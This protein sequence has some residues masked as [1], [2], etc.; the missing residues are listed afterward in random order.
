M[1]STTSIRL[2]VRG[3]Q[4]QM[5][6]RS[7]AQPHTP[8]SSSSSKGSASV[9]ATLFTGAC[10]CAVCAGKCKDFIQ[11]SSCK[12]VEPGEGAMAECIEDLVAASESGEGA[13]AGA[14]ACSKQQPQWQLAGCSS[15]QAAAARRRQQQ[16]RWQLM[17]VAAQHSSSSS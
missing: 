11:G 10:R 12:D 8:A 13:D 9:R 3:Q 17:Y 5:S 15:S 1:T 7:G 14:G 4:L 2:Q 16:H 6:L